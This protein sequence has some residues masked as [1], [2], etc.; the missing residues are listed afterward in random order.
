M[1]TLPRLLS[2][3]G[4]AEAGV[5]GQVPVAFVVLKAGSKVSA[6]ELLGYTAQ[7]L[8]RYKQPGLPCLGQGPG[9]LLHVLNRCARI[10]VKRWVVLVGG[11]R[12]AWPAPPRKAL[13]HGSKSQ[14]LHLTRSCVIQAWTLDTNV[15]TSRFRQ[16]IWFTGFGVS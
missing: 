11:L 16:W 1:S 2:H 7:K 3:P 8:A 4:I 12:A 6:E 15:S 5:W 10:R 14:I 13:I 9:G